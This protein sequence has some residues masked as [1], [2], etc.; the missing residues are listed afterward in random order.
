MNLISFFLFFQKKNNNNSMF[1]LN[2]KL[3]KSTYLRDRVPIKKR[4]IEGPSIPTCFLFLQLKFENGSVKVI[5]IN[6]W[7]DCLDICYFILFDLI[8]K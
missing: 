4:K 3:R 1:R 2:G 5:V 7:E 8:I 6:S